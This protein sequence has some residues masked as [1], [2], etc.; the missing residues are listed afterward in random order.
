MRITITAKHVKV[1]ARMKDYARQKLQRL[2]RYF[3]RL[4][5]I[6]VTL[7]KEG[8]DNV[9]EVQISTSNHH[10]IVAVVHNPENMHAAVDL[11]LDKAHRQVKRL[12]EK[13]RSHKGEVRRRKLGRD[14][15]KL[16]RRIPKET[17]YEDV[18]NE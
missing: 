5:S 7:D 18:V 12:K 1:T 11:C 13:L 15:K 16:T 6:R 10:Q 9:C 2:E 17:T 8:K 3:D 4:Q 14:V